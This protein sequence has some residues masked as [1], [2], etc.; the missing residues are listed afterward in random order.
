MQHAQDLEGLNT[1][2]TDPCICLDHVRKTRGMQTS[3][4]DLLQSRLVIRS[5]ISTSFFTATIKTEVLIEASVDCRCGGFT[6]KY[7]LYYS[8]YLRA[9]VINSWVLRRKK[10]NM[11]WKIC[12]LLLTSFY[13]VNDSNEDIIIFKMWNCLW[14]G[15]E[16]YRTKLHVISTLLFINLFKISFGLF[17]AKF[18]QFYF[19]LIIL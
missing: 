10:V 15:I 14:Y 9:K 12:C 1:V 4:A 19:W 18:L 17:R 11:S 5:D 13:F 8:L 16:I 3:L 6:A 7:D 2:C